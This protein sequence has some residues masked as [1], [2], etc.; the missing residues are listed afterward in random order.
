MF[1]IL[2]S[3][4]SAG[5]GAAILYGLAINK[6]NEMMNSSQRT[7]LWK[8]ILLSLVWEVPAVAMAVPALKKRI[9]S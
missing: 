6:V 5:V 9:F 3:L 4:H 1:T 8:I 7:P 2:L